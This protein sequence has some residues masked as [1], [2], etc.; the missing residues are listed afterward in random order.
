VKI[1]F[2]VSFVYFHIFL[3]SSPFFHSP[4]FL[5][6]ITPNS[7]TLLMIMKDKKKHSVMLGLP[8]TCVG[9]KESL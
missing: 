1:L 2:G 8:H 6:F 4:C 3:L 5:S 9:R 7:T